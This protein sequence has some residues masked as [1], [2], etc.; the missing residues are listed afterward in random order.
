MNYKTKNGRTR[1]VNKKSKRLTLFIVVYLLFSGYCLS[2]E[3]GIVEVSESKLKSA[4]EPISKYG[5][6][7]NPSGYVEGAF[8][9]GKEKEKEKTYYDVTPTGYSAIK[10]PALSF[11]ASAVKAN[12]IIVYG[13]NFDRDI[14]HKVNLRIY[15]LQ[16]TLIGQA[17]SVILDP[18]VLK[19]AENGDIYISGYKEAKGLNKNLCY[20]IKY[21]KDGKLLWQRVIESGGIPSD[22]VIAASNEYVAVQNLIPETFDYTINIFDKNGTSMNNMKFFYITSFEFLPD[23]SYVVANNKSLIFNKSGS[24]LKSASDII[25]EGELLE[26]HSIYYYP[27]KNLVIAITQD[28]VKKRLIFQGYDYNTGI[29]KFKKYLNGYSITHKPYKALSIDDACLRLKTDN[30]ELSIVLKDN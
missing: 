18:F 13:D 7:I 11:L 14:L 3:I 24:K 5:T 29:I 15:T 8:N 28:I 22:I 20:L 26:Y 10:I 23:N 27:S 9:V 25:Y 2:Q 12:R 21:D 1:P 16:G 4:V 19:L 30:T 17:D 6:L